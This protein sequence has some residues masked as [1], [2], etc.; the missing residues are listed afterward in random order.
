M[1]L[2]EN[3]RVWIYQSNRPFTGQELETLNDLLSGFTREWSAHGHALAAGFEIR[4]SRFLILIV[5]ENQ[6]GAT[7]CSIDK[8]VNLM[9]SI[10]QDFGV[11]L[12]DRFNIAYKDGEEV[13][14]CSRSEFEQ[15]IANGEITAQTIVFNNLVTTL[16]ELDWKWEVPLRESWHATVFG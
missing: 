3:S 10:E 6:A 16:K 8:S 2:S 12:F 4:Y 9:K 13:V 15:R 14:S 11:A 7:G 5:D 1:S